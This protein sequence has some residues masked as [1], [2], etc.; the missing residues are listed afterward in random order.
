MQAF[1]LNY[2]FIQVPPKGEMVTKLLML[3]NS[4]H[5]DV[6]Q[7]PIET[8]HLSQLRQNMQRPFPKLTVPEII[9]STQQEKLT[10]LNTC[11]NTGSHACL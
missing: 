1:F 8:Q 5:E 10:K 3:N 6:P 2:R 7:R 9:R 11:G 4:R